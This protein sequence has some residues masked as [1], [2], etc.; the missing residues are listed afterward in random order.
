METNFVFGIPFKAKSFSKDWDKVC[1]NLEQTLFSLSKQS[2][3]NFKVYIAA[4]EVPQI[5][6]YNLNVEFLIAPFP[7]PKSIDEVG[8]DKG[9]K[10]RMIGAKLK[11]EKYDSVY[12]MHLDADDLIAPSL[13]DIIHND[14]NKSGYLISRGYM[15]DVMNQ[16]I[17]VC[18]ENHSV[19]WRHC[20]SSAILYIKNDELPKN[21]DD[22][23]CYYS[24][25]K[26]HSKYVN[27]AN[28]YGRSFTELDSYLAVY[29]VNHGENNRIFKVKGG[30]KINYVKRNIITDENRIEEILLDFP[31]LKINN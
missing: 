27:V 25:F 18:D 2:N 22:I 30:R 16:A 20:G 26:S 10:K 15:Y 11:K 28:E 14:D 23:H 5:N 24:K 7:P 19:F 12:F 1:M 8:K 6:L 9:R 4:H 21:Y 31:Q 17:A 13:V 3:L 29:M